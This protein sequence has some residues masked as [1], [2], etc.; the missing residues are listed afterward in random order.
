MAK[1]L[2]KS[3]ADFSGRRFTDIVDEEDILVAEKVCKD[4]VDLGVVS[5][6]DVR[7]GTLGQLGAIA[8]QGEEGTK[9][10]DV[11]DLTP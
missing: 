8:S 4:S 9:W 2:E 6:V 7:L 10:R 5:G 1:L 3:A 11:V